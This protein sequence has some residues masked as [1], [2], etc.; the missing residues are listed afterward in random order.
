MRSEPEFPDAAEPEL[1]ARLPLTPEL[2]L[3]T[4]VTW[5]LPLLVAVPSLEVIINTPPVAVV[6]RPEVAVTVP[7]VPLVPLPTSTTT[8]PPRPAVAP[9]EPTARIPLLLACDDAELKTNRPLVPLT[10]L[11]A[12]VTLSIPLLDEVPS[13]LLRAI[14][15]PDAD[16]LRPEDMATMPPAPL[17]PL[18]EA[19]HNTPPRPAVDAPDPIVPSP[20]LLEA[21]VPELKTRIPLPP[22]APELAVFM[23]TSP[24]LEV[25]PSPLSSCTTPPVPD[26]LRPETQY[27]TP[28]APLVPPPTATLTA[29]PRPK[30]AVPLPI[31]SGPELPPFVDPELKTSI[32]LA[33]TVPLLAD[34]RS[35]APLLV[36][37]PSL[38]LTQM[39]PPVCTVLR[40]D[41]I[42]TR[43]AAPLVP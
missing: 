30:V 2:P 22:E 14:A 33:P 10:A 27:E 11:F 12:V 16:M 7:P 38:A 43:S 41:S 39:H 21:A 36:A 1:N 42:S 23:V 4:V 8:A 32:P 34:R 6:D 19:T 18:P 28:P 35:T 9:P 40:P 3:L 13:P 31:L 20:L 5:M 37:V 24:L 29:P 17:V 15:P 25:V 26:V